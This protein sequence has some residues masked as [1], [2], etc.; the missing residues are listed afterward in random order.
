MVAGGS[1]VPGET[2]GGVLCAGLRLLPSLE[3][4]G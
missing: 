1:V 3:C 4:P 2:A